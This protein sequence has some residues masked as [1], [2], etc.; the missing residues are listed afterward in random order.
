MEA[1][2]DEVAFTLLKGEMEPVVT[3]YEI[4]RAHV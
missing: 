2:E 3:D 1:S 4:G